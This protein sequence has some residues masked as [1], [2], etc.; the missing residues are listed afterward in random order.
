MIPEFGADGNLPPGVHNATWPEIVSRFGATPQRRILLGGL[1][2]ALQALR[3]AGCRRAYIDG[4]FVTSKMVPAD[5]DGCYDTTGVDFEHL[6]P[7]LQ[8]FSDQRAAQKAEFRG[9]L[10]PASW[11]ADRHGRP[12]FEFFQRDRDGNAKGIV[13]LDLSTGGLP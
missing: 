12:F 11:Q 4:S 5:Y 1:L 9:E 7:V 8:E 6:H 3:A 13:V 2:R 10:F